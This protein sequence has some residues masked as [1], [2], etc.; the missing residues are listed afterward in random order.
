MAIGKFHG[1]MMLTTPK[2]S[3]ATAT[4]IP[5]RTESMSSP[6]VTDGLAGVKAQHLGR[7]H[8][9]PACFGQRLPFL[10]SEEVAQ[11][12]GPGQDFFEARCST[13]ARDLRSR[14]RPTGKS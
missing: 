13:S 11:L 4:S 8:D 1:V 5:G 10:T 6:R 7:S 9:L 12:V 3:R 2:G 14:G